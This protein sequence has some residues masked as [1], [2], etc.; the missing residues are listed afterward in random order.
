MTFW[1][2]REP[3]NNLEFLAKKTGNPGCYLLL[4]MLKTD[5]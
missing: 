4:K 2:W 1:N 5:D 3:G